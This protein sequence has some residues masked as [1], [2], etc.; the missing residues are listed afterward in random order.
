M[1][2][3]FSLAGL[4][5]KLCTPR[6]I[7][8]SQSLRPFLTA[9]QK[10]TDCTVT[11]QLTSTLPPI[12][13]GG[14]WHAAQ[15]FLPN[16]V[17]H[18][19]GVEGKAF[20]VT[21]FSEKD[22]KISVQNAYAS[23]VSGSEGIF[24]RIGLET[25]LLKYHGLLLHASLIDFENKAIVFAGASGVGKSTQADLWH[26]T[27]GANIL[28]GDRTALRKDGGWIAYGCPYA[29]TS[30]IYKNAHAPLKA[31][32]VLAQGEENCLKRLSPQEALGLLYPEFSLHRW[33]RTF[34]EKATDLVL[35]LIGDVPVYRFVCRPDS[36]AV[37]ALKEGLNL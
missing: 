25:L 21:D 17:F 28:N 20:A 15:Y 13:E 6:E 26:K 24:H 22:V 3:D 5:I 7:T 37:Y 29:G 27:L 2:Y 14:V 8:I 9:P 4:R 36:G 19:Q 23:C 31:I 12:S 33:E 34:L 1:E 32:V 11:V 35:E 30:G 16:R 10:K 18:C